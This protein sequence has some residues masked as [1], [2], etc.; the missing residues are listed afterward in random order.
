MGRRRGARGGGADA[1][2]GARD[3][4]DRLLIAHGGHSNRSGAP[5]RRRPI[6]IMRRSRWIPQRKR[7]IRLVVALGAA[8]LLAAAL[9]YTSFTA[10]TEAKQPSQLLSGRA[11]RALR[12][13]RPGRAG[14]GRARAATT[15]PSASPTATAA[16]ASRS[17]T[18][19]RCPTRSAAGGR[20]SSPAR[21]QDGTF[22]GERDTLVTKCPSKFTAEERIHSLGSA[23]LALAFLTALFAVAA[24]LIGAGGDRR[25]VDSSR[26]AVYAFCALLTICVIVDRVGLPRRRLRLRGRRRPLVDDHRDLLQVHRDVVEPGRARCCSGPG[27]CRSPRARSSSSPATATARSSPGRPRC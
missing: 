26:R 15:S 7:K 10:S 11:G 14:L 4:E 5:A 2:A 23:A 3:Q 1:A 8:V 17:P 22:V 25:W 18:T 19:A 13:D 6:A 24:A 21:S 9:V 27:C 16:R 12:P 20:S